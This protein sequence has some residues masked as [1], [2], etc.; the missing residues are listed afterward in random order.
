MS[1][2]VLTLIS[3][4]SHRAA[5][6]QAAALNEPRSLFLLFQLFQQQLVFLLVF[7][8]D[9]AELAAASQPSQ[10]DRASG[11]ERSSRVKAKTKI[12]SRVIN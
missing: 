9:A 12:H 5:V 7:L 6:L 11:P 3:V 1:P 4:E 2:A 8:V 10:T